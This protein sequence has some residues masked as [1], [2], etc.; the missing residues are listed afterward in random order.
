[1]GTSVTKG[2]DGL[3]RGFACGDK[4][5][6]DD[7]TGI[8][9]QFAFDKVLAAVLFGCGTDVDHREVKFLSDECGQGDGARGY[10]GDDVYCGVLV[11]N[12]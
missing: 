2:V 3:E 10:S 7:Y 12:E 11:P 4:V 8:F 5:F 9:G 1:M 6:D